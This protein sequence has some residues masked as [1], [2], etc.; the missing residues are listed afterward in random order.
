MSMIRSENISIEMMREG[1][2]HRIPTDSGMGKLFRPFA[3]GDRDGRIANLET[4]YDFFI[5]DVPDPDTA[6]IQDPEIDEKLRQQPDVH[7]CMRI[8]ELTVAS[9]PCVIEPSNKRKVDPDLAQLVADYVEEVFES[10]PSRSELYRQL[11]NA[12]LM[13]GQGIEFMWAKVDNAE[14]PVQFFPV[15]KTRFV[16]D[17]LGNMAILSRTTPVWGTYVSPNPTRFN[18]GLY[19]FPTPPGKFIYHKYMAEGGP[20]YRPAAEGYVYWGRGEDTNLYLPVT[21][22]QFVLRFRMK[23]LEKHG[24]PTTL[25]YHPDSD[26]VTSDVIRIANSLRGE[27]IVTIP[28]PAGTGQENDWYTIDMLDP[29]G[30]G[31]AAFTDFSENWTKPRVEKILLGGANL[32]EVGSHGSYAATVKQHDSG[33]AI[34]FRYDAKIINE[35]IDQQIIPYIVR[36]RWPQIP[37]D[38]FPNHRLAYEEREEQL[39]NLEILRSAAEMVPIKQDEVYDLFDLDRPDPND[40]TVYLGPGQQGGEPGQFDGFPTPASLKGGQTPVGSGAGGVAAGASAGGNGSSPRRGRR[41]PTVRQR[42]A[43]RRNTTA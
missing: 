9:M 3:L 13:G 41:L 12:V 20:W 1:A 39:A 14:V 38:Y 43:T 15:H 32:L 21:F 10:L 17:R 37:D 16:F 25:L 34:I 29:P 4:L 28:R 6:L 42:M 26:E 31:A 24:M 33:A 35:T 18:S 22:D 27:S 8:R 11:Q 7:A 36:A 30:T 19:A 2:G 23:W 5:N 40:E